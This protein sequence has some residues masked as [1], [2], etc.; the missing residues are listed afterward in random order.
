MFKKKRDDSKFRPH[1]KNDDNNDNADYA[2]K[3]I[4]KSYKATSKKLKQ[5][6]IT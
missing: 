4:K 6:K 5:Y 1:L 2:S 3:Y